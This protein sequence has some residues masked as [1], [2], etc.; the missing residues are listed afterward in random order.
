MAAVQTLHGIDNSALA[1]V[2]ASSP[3]T[4][5]V[6]HKQ[7]KKSSPNAPDTIETKTSSSLM[8]VSILIT[9]IVFVVVIA[10]FDLLREKL[11]YERTI[12]V[13]GSGLIAPEK[14]DRDR[15][16]LIAEET[17]AS[18]LDFVISVTIIAFIT[19]PVLFYVYMRL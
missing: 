10:Y 5:P 18:V 16:R 8:I 3:V 1:G 14:K 6:S 7:S 4:V 9:I 2:I 13:T 11:V 19:L 17:Y 15:I 12:R